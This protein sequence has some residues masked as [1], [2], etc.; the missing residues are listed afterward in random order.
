MR[1]FLPTRRLPLRHRFV[2]FE[3]NRG[4]EV[5]VLIIHV[6]AAALCIDRIAFGLAFKCQFFFLAQSLTVQN[7][8]RFV[9]RYGNPDFFC[10][11]YID[12]AVGGSI[13]VAAGLARE[14]PFIN[15]ADTG[16]GPVTDIHHTLTNRYAARLLKALATMDFN[17]LCRKARD[18]ADA[19]VAGVHHVD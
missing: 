9:A 8:D 3:I 16:V 19:A 13:D 4:R 17:Y 6:E 5:L 14:G 2:C 11:R 10:W 18:L 7:T 15:G 1:T 12:D